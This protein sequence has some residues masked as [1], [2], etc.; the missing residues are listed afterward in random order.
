MTYDNPPQGEIDVSK[1]LEIYRNLGTPGKP[2]ALLAGMAGEWQARTRTFMETGEPPVESTGSC[3]RKMILD[4]RYLQE[5]FHGN[6]MGVP[7]TGISLTGFDNHTSKFV[8]TWV[9]SLSTAI[10]YFT[11]RSDS[12]GRTIT[13]ECRYDDPIKGPMTMRS[14]TRIVDEDTHEFEMYG[15]DRSGKEEKMMAIT[16]TRNK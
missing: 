10:F 16:Y 5:D 2:H 4:G 1:K 3:E 9:D 13:Q 7:F 15:I 6:M 11:G 8:S 14:V 12:Q